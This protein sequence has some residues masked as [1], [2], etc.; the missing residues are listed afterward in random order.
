M[1]NI[2]KNDIHNLLTANDIDS[3]IK[4]ETMAVNIYYEDETRTVYEWEIKGIGQGQITINTKTSEIIDDEK[5]GEEFCRKVIVFY[6]AQ[7]I[8]VKEKNNE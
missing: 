3:L 2:I 6:R 7:K 1:E 4:P 5:M 8:L